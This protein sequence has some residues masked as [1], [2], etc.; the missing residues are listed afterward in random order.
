MKPVWS[1]LN[2]S[3][4]VSGKT[5]PVLC[6]FRKNETGLMLSMAIKPVQGESVCF[7]MMVKPVWSVSNRFDFSSNRCDANAS[8]NRFEFSSNRFDLSSNRFDA[9]D[10]HQSCL[11][12]TKLRT[13][14]VKGS[15]SFFA[16][17]MYSS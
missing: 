9:V 14:A 6:G 3:K 1:N 5:K 4:P 7:T 13:L 16:V 12:H 10:G 15:C 2:Q 17:H 8:S 11:A